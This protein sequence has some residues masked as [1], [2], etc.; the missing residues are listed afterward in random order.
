MKILFVAS[1]GLPFFKTGGLAD[2]VEALPKAL[3]ALGHEV[4]V[5]LPRYRIM[6]EV[7]QVRTSV[8]I[9]MGTTSRTVAIVGGDVVNGVRYYFVED[10]EYFDRDHLYGTAGKD[11]PDN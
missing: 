8:T 2:V 7:G 3:V 4:V 5:L 9:L 10:P 1:E 11:Y 6:Q